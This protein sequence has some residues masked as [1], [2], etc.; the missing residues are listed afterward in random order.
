MG[1][2]MDSKENAP[3]SASCCNL[4]YLVAKLGRNEAAARKLAGLFLENV[5]H[6]F[7]RLERAASARD[8][9]A[10]LHVVHDVRGHCVLFAASECLEKSR[11]META[12]RELI[13]G[14]GIY[15]S[16]LDWVAETAELR[17]RLEDVVA[18]LKA[19]LAQ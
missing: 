4:D 18:E 3:G 2:G 16:D 5:G 12:L 17:A 13:A 11:F 8:L 10:L 15:Y 1:Q 7:D 9:Q 14:N 19:Y 6:L